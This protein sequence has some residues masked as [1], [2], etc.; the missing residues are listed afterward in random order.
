MSQEAACASNATC[1]DPSGAHAFWQ[2][3]SVLEGQQRNRFMICE[4]LSTSS[5]ARRLPNGSSIK[6]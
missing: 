6:G 4:A 3:M 1:F 2:E 5:N